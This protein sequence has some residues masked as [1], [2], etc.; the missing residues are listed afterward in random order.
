MKRAHAY[1]LFAAIVA[2]MF[3][4]DRLSKAWA[5]AAGLA[6]G[7]NEVDLG[8]IRL[9]MVH[10]AG[11]AFGMGQGAQAL[12]IGIAV[13]IVVAI[14]VWLAVV[15]SYGVL[16][17]AAAALVVAGGLGN[18]VDRIAQGYVTDFLEFTFIDF[19]VFNVA[20]ICVTVGAVVFIL[21]TLAVSF[22]PA[23]AEDAPVDGEDAPEDGTR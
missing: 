16:E 20:D 8:L 4:I 9:T 19:P 21:A 1:T 6:P 14:L 2:V 5:I 13:F 7:M 10:N 23:S 15:R 22:A 17:V 11:A 3:V 12:F 18:M